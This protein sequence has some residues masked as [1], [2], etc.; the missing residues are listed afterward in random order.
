MA[1][2]V[3]AIHAARPRDGPDR[4]HGSMCVVSG[5]E[6]GTT[7]WMTG[8]SPV[9][10]FYSNRTSLQSRRREKSRTGTPSGSLSP[11]RPEAADPLR[12]RID[13]PRGAILCSSFVHDRRHRRTRHPAHR[14]AR[15]HHRRHV[16]RGR[17]ATGGRVDDGGAATPAVGAVAPH[18]RAGPPPRFTDRRRPAAHPPPARPGRAAPRPPTAAA[19]D[20]PQVLGDCPGSRHRRLRRALAIPADRPADGGAGDAAAGAAAAAAAV[21][22]AGGGVASRA[23]APGARRSGP[24]DV[25]TRYATSNSPAAPIPP[26]THIVI[27]T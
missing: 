5:P 17:R 26:P 10:T 15:P 21:P 14:T 2:L 6:P 3:P 1:G 4:S 12:H 18:R 22:D 7:A 24:G 9:M 23:E 8:T 13:L 27:T 19:A 25:R 11:R 20:G 16:R